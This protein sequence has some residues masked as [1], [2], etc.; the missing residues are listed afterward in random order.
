[1]T[2]RTRAHVSDGGEDLT[3]VGEVEKPWK[4]IIYSVCLL[5]AGTCM[6]AAGLALHF[7]DDPRAQGAWDSCQLRNPLPSSELLA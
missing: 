3:E 1:M 2:P 6:L 5:L 4:A 7:S